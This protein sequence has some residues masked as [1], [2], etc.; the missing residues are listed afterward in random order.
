MKELDLVM[1][2]YLERH[3]EAAP[4]T[5]QAQFRELLQL[6]DPELYS[7]LLARGGPDDPEFAEL[8]AVLRGLSA[9]NRHGVPD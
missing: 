6:Q 8:L 3:Y 1:S 2:G 9:G 7:L 4:D 5:Q